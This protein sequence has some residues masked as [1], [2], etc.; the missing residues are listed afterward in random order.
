MRGEGVVATLLRALGLV[1]HGAHDRLFG[2]QL[3]D[4]GCHGILRAGES[5]GALEQFT[6]L[7]RADHGGDGLDTVVAFQLPQGEIGDRRP[8]G[9]QLGFGVGDLPAQLRDLRIGA[10]RCHHGGVVLL[11]GRRRVRVQT[12]E[13]LPRL[14]QFDLDRGDPVLI[15]GSLDGGHR[16]PDQADDRHHEQGEAATHR[17]PR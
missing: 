17:S 10:L 5:A 3:R 11:G 15:G 16:S 9:L 1:E 12:V 8:F 2:L 13:R 6:R 4:L 14:D 7:A